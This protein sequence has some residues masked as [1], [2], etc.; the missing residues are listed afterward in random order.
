MNE[1]LNVLKL[2]AT[3]LEK[4]GVAYMITGSVAANFYSVPRMTRD[5]DIVV[6]VKI[7]ETDK[8]ADLFKNLFDSLKDLD[9]PYLMQWI[10]SLGLHKI[11]EAVKR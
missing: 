9:T 6:E 1:Q 8:V 5:I 11:Y 2:V 4:A 10:S 7:G 3:R